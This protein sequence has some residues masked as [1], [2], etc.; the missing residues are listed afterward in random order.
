MDLLESVR[1]DL[2]HIVDFGFFSF[3]ARPLFWLL[4]WTHEHIVPNWGWAII[5]VTVFINVAL[6]P[7]KWKSTKSMKKMQALQPVIKQINEKYKGLSIRDPKKAQQNEEVMAV[8][9]KYG[10]NPMGGCLPMVLQLPFFIAFYSMLTS[11]IELR[12]ASWLWVADLSAPEQIAVRVLPL[13]MILTQFWQQ[14]MTPQPTVDPAQAKMMKFM[15][16]L[17]GFFFYGFSSGLVL[18][19]LTGNVVGVAQQ[20]ILNRLSSEPLEIEQ[21]RRGRKKK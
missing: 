5:V 19:W 15:P 16:L 9:K 13:A 17:M 20:A 7:L 4:R 8:Y 14:A 21:P 1:P 3:L 10:V 11:A 2:Q 6:F 12:H 18:F